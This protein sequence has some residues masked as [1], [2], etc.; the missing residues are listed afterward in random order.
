VRRRSLESRELSS[1]YQIAVAAN[2]RSLGDSFPRKRRE[3]ARSQPGQAWLA[4]GNFPLES[5]LKILEI[6]IA[7]SE[8]VFDEDLRQVADVISQEIGATGLDVHGVTYS[9][10]ADETVAQFVM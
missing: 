10:K 9:I 2:P 7:V 5:Q 6:R 8:I 3:V 1:R 4:A